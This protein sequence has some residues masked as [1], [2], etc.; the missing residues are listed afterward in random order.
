MDDPYCAN[1]DWVK[2]PHV[3]APNCPHETLI[4]KDLLFMTNDLSIIVSEVT[5]TKN[6]MFP[7]SIHKQC[8]H[9]T[10][11]LSSRAGETNHKAMR[12]RFN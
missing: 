12:R 7:Y 2:G 6:E 11:Q 3:K 10:G 4:L 9:H 1:A 8:F 5:Y